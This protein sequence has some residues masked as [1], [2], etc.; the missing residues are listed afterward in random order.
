MR[1]AY[2]H[3]NKASAA[4]ANALFILQGCVKPAPGQ[5]QTRPNAE[6]ESQQEQ[7]ETPASIYTQREERWKANGMN[8]GE[9]SLRI[10]AYAHS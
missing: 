4:I 10:R 7:Q 6:L 8:N 9:T 5:Q 1:P 3:E 2:L